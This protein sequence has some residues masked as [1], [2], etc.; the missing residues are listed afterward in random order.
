MAEQLFNGHV[1]ESFERYGALGFLGMEIAA[2]A[3]QGAGVGH[4]WKNRNDLVEIHNVQKQYKP[5]IFRK[6]SGPAWGTISKTALI[7][8]TLS[9]ASK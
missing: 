3:Q 7:S 5:L 8:F 6:I 9:S 2:T 1:D 4:F